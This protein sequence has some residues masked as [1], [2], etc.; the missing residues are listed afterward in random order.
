MKLNIDNL[1]Q[2]ASA[3]KVRSIPAVFLIHNGQVIDT[4][5]GLPSSDVLTKFLQ[6]A[7]FIDQLQND[8]T[9]MQ[10]IMD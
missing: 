9:V 3:L 2:I 1:P 4:F 8:E 6:T 7:L 5:V 10:R